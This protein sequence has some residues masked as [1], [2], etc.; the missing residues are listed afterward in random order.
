V[1]HRGA[2]PTKQNPG[3]LL[4]C[5]GID[6]KSIK[7]A[8]QPHVMAKATYFVDRAKAETLFQFDEQDAAA[9]I[10]APLRRGEA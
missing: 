7:Q 3:A 10:I 2:T 4:L 8:N 5:H 1:S 6:L 9:A